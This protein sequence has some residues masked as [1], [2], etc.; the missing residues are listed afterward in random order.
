MTEPERPR[1]IPPPE[2]PLSAPDTDETPE[3]TE[4][5]PEPEPWTAGRVSEWNAYYDVYVAL[6]VLLLVFVVSAHLITHSSIW[7][8]LQTG[9]LIAETSAPVVTDP[10]SYTEPGHRWVN[11]PWLFE[12]SHAVVHKAASSLTPIDRNDPVASKAFGEQVA[13][14]ALV[15]IN[16]LV[17]TLTVLLLLTIRRPGPGLWWSVLCALLAM[18][19]AW[20]PAGAVSGSFGSG[21]VLGGV[22]GVGQVSPESWGGLLLALELLILH[23]TIHLGRRNA[24][25]ALVPVFLLWA[26]LDESFLI[27]LLV[28]AATVIGRLADSPRGAGRPGEDADP[29]SIGRGLAVLGACAAVCLANPSFYR[30]FPA[31]M[32]PLLSFF[33]PT[34]GVLTHDQLSFFGSRIRRPDQAGAGWV[35]LAAY[36]V[37]VVGLGLA[38]FLLNRMRFSLGRFLI[39]ALTASLWALYIRFGSEFAIVFVAVV[40]LNGQ[41][42]YHD[43]F[44]TE[45]R[46]GRGW[47]LW[48]IGGRAVTIIVIFACVAKGMT[49]WRAHPGE[50]QFGFGFRPDDFSFEA[51]E[52]LKTA[53]IRGNILNTSLQQGDSLIW[54][55]YPLRKTFIDGRRHLFTSET[56]RQLEETRLALRDND[57]ARWK[58]LLDRHEISAVMIHESSSPITYRRLMQSPD[59]IPFYDD[60]GVV[61][62]GRADAPEADLAH[63]NAQRLEADAIAYERARPFP[64]FDRAPTPVGWMDEIFQHRSLARPQPHTEAGRRWLAGPGTEG[65]PP[66]YPDPARCLLAIHEARLAL[67]RRPDDTRAFR[68]LATA[69]RF[70]MIEESAML[71]GLTPSP[72]NMEQVLSVP[73]QTRPLMNRFR[74][75]VTSLNFAVQTTPTPR[76]REER[77]DLQGLHLELYQ[78]FL[79]VNYLDLARDHL[80]AAL[81]AAAPGEIVPEVRASM[82]GELAQLEER[83]TEVQTRMGDLAIEQQAGPLDRAGFAMSQGAPGLA[84]R[85]LEEAEQLSGAN[86]ALVKPQLIDLYCDTGQPEKALDLLGG[87]ADADDPNLGSEP[88]GAALRQG[89]VHLLLGNY[90]YAATFWLQR[91]I[92]RI[93]H[94][95]ARLAPAT[96]QS[97]LRGAIKPATRELLTIPSKVSMQATL[98]IE[99]ALCLLEAGQPQTA[100][101]HFT[102]ALTLE[103]GLVTRPLAAYYLEKMGKPVPPA[104][105]AEADTTGATAEAPAPTPAP[106]ETPS[107]PSDD[108][109]APGGPT[110]KD[111]PTGAKPEGKE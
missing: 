1:P 86:P 25:L 73:V 51:A 31:A 11:I 47:A 85:E 40:A 110:R 6:G 9:R 2:S 26:N 19:V 18:G 81:N 78:L 28:L 108:R 107:A 29:L 33:R 61:M 58:P 83:M 95:L 88:G 89:R 68:L 66:S 16:A 49:G 90:E 76:T 96:T 27:G 93:Q 60:G 4:P 97:F 71:A 103:P 62:F 24:V 32:E 10:F 22:G 15:A 72:A 50:A 67:A 7:T 38:S 104:R 52:Y 21:L 54:R 99:A 44:G 87:S 102:Q 63:F 94:E 12:W 59:W 74:Q 8:Q 46:L 34:G 109:S 70:L 65:D 82:S 5:E 84:L 43:R 45:G 39:F 14:G 37:I 3:A 20:T 56:R 23:R 17:R 13:A 69:Y 30:I 100:A 75:R 79:G 53:P 106:A 111:E 42:W 98:E 57:V 55:A 77:V 36:Y 80:Q 64:P 41:E 48:S 92:P 105:G 91:A 101:E 35:Y